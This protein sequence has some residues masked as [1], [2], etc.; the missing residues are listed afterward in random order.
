VARRPRRVLVAPEVDRSI[1][2]LHPQLRRKLRAAADAL[3]ADHTVGKALRDELQGYFSF[4]IGGYRLIYRHLPRD[5]LELVAFG[6]RSRIYLDMVRL[7]R[8]T[9]KER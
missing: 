8:R 6:P 1:S 2:G 7:V 4:R 5:S 3:A 9:R